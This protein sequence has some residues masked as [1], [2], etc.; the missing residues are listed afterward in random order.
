M[1]MKRLLTSD[2]TADALL[3]IKQGTLEFLQDSYKE[4]FNAI[5]GAKVSSLPDA[6]TVPYIIYGCEYTDL[7]TNYAVSAGAAY[8]NGE[9]Y[10]IDAVSST[11][12][13]TGTEVIGISIGTTYQTAANA[14]PV[15]MTDL[16]TI[17]N[18]HQIKKMVIGNIEPADPDYIADYEDLKTLPNNN[19]EY[20]SA[21]SAGNPF[22]LNRSYVGNTDDANGITA[23]LD[24]TL[25]PAPG[26]TVFLSRTVTA[27]GGF[28]ITHPGGSGI[29]FRAK[30]N[31][32]PSITSS[33]VSGVSGSGGALIVRAE[34]MGS[35]GSDKVVDLE[36]NYVP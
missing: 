25:H 24:P 35:V 34:Y 32:V 1:P 13:P 4:I 19:I 10:L 17:V 22:V 31:G 8:Y 33:T 20:N 7:G 5:M 11:A 14:D 2:I 28:S 9:I 16:V 36:V 30:V 29:I 27:G 3:P 26:A 21:F 6:D 18:V 15:T 12:L 23:T